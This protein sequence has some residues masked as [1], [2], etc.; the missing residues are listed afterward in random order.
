MLEDRVGEVLQ[1]WN[2]F[3]FPYLQ[4]PRI[5]LGVYFSLKFRRKLHLVSKG[6]FHDLS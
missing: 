2:I 4:F 1:P 6:R 5:I 3:N